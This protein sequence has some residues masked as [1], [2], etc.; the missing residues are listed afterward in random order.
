MKQS[1]TRLL[2]QPLPMKLISF[3]FASLLALA[4]GLKKHP[5]IAPGTPDP[6]TPQVATSIRE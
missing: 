5:P 1:R 3:A 2:S 6:Y 4:T